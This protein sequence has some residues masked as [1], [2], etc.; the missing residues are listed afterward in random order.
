VLIGGN[1][2]GIIRTSPI[3][4]VTQ[5]DSYLVLQEISKASGRLTLTGADGSAALVVY[6]ACTPEK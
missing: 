4:S 5:R 6:G 1:P 3:Q 2:D